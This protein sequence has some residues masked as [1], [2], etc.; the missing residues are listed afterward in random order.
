MSPGLKGQ[1]L[2]SENPDAGRLYAP[3]HATPLQSPFLIRVVLGGPPD[4]AAALATLMWTHPMISR[5][6]TRVQARCL[7]SWGH[8]VWGDLSLG[9]PRPYPATSRDTAL[10]LVSKGWPVH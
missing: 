6:E 10:T 2:G 4:P 7:L 5:E 3:G 1:A 9:L 8:Q